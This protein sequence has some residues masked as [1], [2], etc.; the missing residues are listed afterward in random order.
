MCELCEKNGWLKPSVY[1]GL[2]NGFH[3]AD[4]A[5]LFPCLRYYGL[6]F[7]CFNPLA[8]G[9]LTSR[10]TRDMAEFEEGS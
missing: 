8:G 6:S 1:Q 9:F 3:R 7:Y 4:E 5:E 2:Y 10:Y